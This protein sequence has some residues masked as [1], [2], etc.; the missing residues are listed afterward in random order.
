MVLETAASAEAGP[1]IRGPLHLSA[2]DHV[3]MDVIDLL[4]PLPTGVEHNPETLV[5]TLRSG[6]HVDRL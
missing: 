1:L 3:G 4:S 6:N 2:T 5:Q